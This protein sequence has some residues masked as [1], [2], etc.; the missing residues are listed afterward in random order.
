MSTK[1]NVNNAS[2]LY[3]YNGTS[4][5]AVSKLFSLWNN[6]KYHINAVSIAK[7]SSQKLR[8]PFAMSSGREICSAPSVSSYQ[9]TSRRKLVRADVGNL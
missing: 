4:C 8:G 9:Q 1:L 2:I 6:K 7:T 5:C 3:I